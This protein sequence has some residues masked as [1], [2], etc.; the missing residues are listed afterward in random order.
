M[1]FYN[2]IFYFLIDFFY[3]KK[4]ISN[5]QIYLSYKKKISKFKNRKFE[6]F[7]ENIFMMGRVS[8][9]TILMQVPQ[10]FACKRNK[11]NVII[12]LSTPCWSIEKIYKKFGVKNFLYYQNFFQTN[13]LKTE[14]Y[15]DLILKRNKTSKKYLGIDFLK[16]LTSTE[17]RINKR[18]SINFNEYSKKYLNK[19]ISNCLNIADFSQ[20][21]IMKFKPKK[22]FFEDRGYI[23]EGIFFS[24][25]LYNKVD[26][27]EVHAGHKSGILS[28]KRYHLKNKDK[29]PISISK[30]LFES[31]KK[32]KI[33]K[34]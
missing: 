10:I 4:I 29:H 18:G 14:E 31:F 9:D 30:K 33:F 15:V 32:K 27:I 19:T 16:L 17:M 23:P 12:L 6:S 5:F 28:Y 20:K 8:I 21:N 24:N 13:H 11:L 34:I 1:N 3:P 22:F 7:N 2:Y 26:V 25:A